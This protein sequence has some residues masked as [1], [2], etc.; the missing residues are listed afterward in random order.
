VETRYS[1]QI[2]TITHLTQFGVKLDSVVTW[3][4][5]DAFVYQ[6][7]I[8]AY[9]RSMGAICAILPIVMILVSDCQWMQRRTI[10]IKTNLCAPEKT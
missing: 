9:K 4:Y 7:S 2:G 6:K 8:H 10:F 5:G 3:R 1:H